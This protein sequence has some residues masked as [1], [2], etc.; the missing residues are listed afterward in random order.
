V[1]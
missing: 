1:F